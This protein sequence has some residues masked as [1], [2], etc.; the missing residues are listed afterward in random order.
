MMTNSFIGPY[1]IIRKIGQGGMCAVYQV[2]EPETKNVVALKTMLHQTYMRRFKREFRAMSRLSHDNIVKVYDFGM[3][4]RRPYFTMEYVEGGNILEFLQ[5]KFLSAGNGGGI[6]VS[7]DEIRLAA[8]TL[9]NICEPLNYI[10]SLKLIHRDLKPANIMTGTDGTVKLMDF[11]LVKDLDIHNELSATQ[12]GVF[13]GTANYIAPEQGI[14]KNVDQRADLYSLG[15]I[16]YEAL[17]GRLPFTADSF[18]SIIM[19]HLQEIPESPASLNKAVPAPLENIILKLLEKNPEE[20][21]QSA[22]EL[23]RELEEFLSEYYQLTAVAFADREGVMTPEAVDPLA[24]LLLPG[25]VGRRNA[26]DFLEN[27][28]RRLIN[29]ENR[30]IAV[31]G[32]SGIGK[33]RL[34]KE[35][36][37]NVLTSRCLYFKTA[38]REIGSYPYEIFSDIVESALKKCLKG[39]SSVFHDMSDFELKALQKYFPQ[40]KKWKPLQKTPPLPPLPPEQEKIRTFEAFRSLVELFSLDQPLL[41]VIDDFQWADELSLECLLY[42]RRN[43]IIRNSAKQSG[44]KAPR[45]MLMILYRDEE[46][47]AEHPSGASLKGLLSRKEIDMIK[48]ERFSREQ[49]I[50]I[51]QMMTNTEE[52]PEEF[53]DKLYAETEGNPL[54]IEEIVKALAQEQVIR[55]AESGWIID[56]EHFDHIISQSRTEFVSSQISELPPAIFNIISRRLEDLSQTTLRILNHAAVIGKTFDFNLLSEVTGADEDDLLDSIG[57]LLKMDFIVEKSGRQADIFQFKQNMIRRI[58]YGRISAPRRRKMHRETAAAIEKLYAPGLERYYETLAYHYYAAKKDIKAVHYSL[59]SGSKFLNAYLFTKAHRYLDPAVELIEHADY[60]DEN[61]RLSDHFKLLM[62]RS[63]LYEMSGRLNEA[64]DVLA[65]SLEL[66]RKLADAESEWKSLNMLGAIHI[67]LGNKEKAAQYYMPAL[68]VAERLNNINFLAATYNAVGNVYQHKGDML[69]ALETFDK[70][71][72]ISENKNPH[73]VGDA[74]MNI[75]NVHYASGRYDQALEHFTRALNLYESLEAKPLIIKSLTN[76][77]VVYYT[78]GDFDKALF[79]YQKTMELSRQI[80]DLMGLA[81]VHNNS[82]LILLEKGDFV[83]AVAEF[84]QSLELCRKMGDRLGSAIALI[85]IGAIK[86]KEGDNKTAPAHFEES[87]EISRKIEHRML[88]AYNL[89]YIAEY[90]R[91]INQPGSALDFYQK[92]K[93]LASSINFQKLQVLADLGTALVQAKKENPENAQS[94]ISNAIEASRSM[95]DHELKIKSLLALMHI[96]TVQ[97]KPNEVR[98]HTKEI[99]RL[100]SSQT[101]KTYAWE[102]LFLHGKALAALNKHKPAYYSFFHALKIIDQIKE[103]VEPHLKKEFLNQPKINEVIRSFHEINKYFT[104]SEPPQI[105]HFAGR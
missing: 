16:A 11:G 89:Y 57:E 75:G 92:T 17:C 83:H 24:M 1:K 74:L 65:E 71:L 44:K 6:P 38:A 67:Q 104:P 80:G 46:L 12:T 43:L 79:H 86:I 3:E 5:E 41:F 58:L 78:K 47:S 70:A 64:R 32:E 15:V 85:N 62:I 72:R 68:K 33:S 54:Y 95:N 73:H 84:Q 42:I 36:E 2:E 25:F 55:Q 18:V 101:A 97:N 59:L 91:N 96:K 14:G 21:C 50:Q 23:S 102:V 31:E 37:T 103:V 27:N 82:G 19:K 28:F 40:L 51:I 45:L 39:E 4:E 20:R 49:A 10:H 63:R 26:L 9:R 13:M 98:R 94:L 30:F 48:L 22:L 77:G 81:S 88:A 34:I 76:I 69:K 52:W 53:L 105:P 61:Q 29:Y 56:P 35:W 100:I 60:P 93:K 99:L 7:D 8:E 90:F 87:L 66:T